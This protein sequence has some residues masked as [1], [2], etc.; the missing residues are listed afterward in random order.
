MKKYIYLTLISIIFFVTGFYSFDSLRNILIVHLKDLH[1]VNYSMTSI[2]SDSLEFGIN[3]GIVPFVFV[4][5]W[6]KNNI[7][8]YK[9]KVISVFIFL[10]TVIAF[11]TIRDYILLFKNESMKSYFAQP[12]T[13]ISTN[14]DSLHIPLYIFLGS[15][16]GFIF[17]FF[18]LKKNK[19]EN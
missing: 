11:M 10:V 9:P 12:G 13:S 16:L 6:K 5:I 7:Q 17:A 1:P 8:A 15:V 2:V 3:C 14:A 4:F 18:Y 19:P